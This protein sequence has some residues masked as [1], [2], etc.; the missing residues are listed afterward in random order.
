MPL[1]TLLAEEA[2]QRDPSDVNGLLWLA[3]HFQGS[4]EERVARWQHVV[5][6]HPR[7]AS[8]HYHLACCFG[9]G[10]RPDWPSLVHLRLAIE[11][12]G[13]PSSCV[14]SWHY[15]LAGGMRHLIHDDEQEAA[16]TQ[17]EGK[18]TLSAVGVQRVHDCIAQYDLYLGLVAV[19][20]RKVAEAH[21][22]TGGH[23]DARR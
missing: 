21:Y 3:R 23:V 16:Q 8:A 19:D 7:N 1:F 10:A 14:A 20:D 22:C 4:A 6:L 9:F 17:A 11:C 2:L 15:D 18:R 13:G 12:D 5:R